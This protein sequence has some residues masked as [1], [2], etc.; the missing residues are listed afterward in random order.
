MWKSGPIS[1]VEDAHLSGLVAPVHAEHERI[2]VTFHGRP[3]AA[4]GAL[5]DLESLE[6]TIAILS[7]TD[8]VAMR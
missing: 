7:D 6:E 4:L 3:T 2:T 1:A 8:T 5:D